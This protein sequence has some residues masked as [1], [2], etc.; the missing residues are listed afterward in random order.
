MKKFNIF[1]SIPAIAVGILLLVSAITFPVIAE[2][3]QL[4]GIE[5]AGK[6]LDVNPLEI[7]YLVAENSQAPTK[8]EDIIN[9][10][11]EEE[12]IFDEI[13]LL[14][15]NSREVIGLSNRE[16]TDSESERL[17]ELRKKFVKGMIKSE[18]TLPIG[19]NLE[20]PYYN[21][22]N[23]TYY[24]AEAEMT[25]EQLLQIID[26]DAKL[27]IAF[28]KFREAYI[29]KVMDNTDIRISEEEAIRIAKDTIENVYDVELDNMKITCS[30]D[31]TESNIG[32][33]W[34]VVFLPKNLDTLR[35]QEKLYWT[36]FSRVDVYDGKIIF[37]DSFYSNQKAERE[38]AAET[39]L[40]NIEEHKKLAEEALVD[41]L[42]I[43]D[44]E[45]LKAYI[46]K[47]DNLLKYNVTSKS[48]FLIYKAEDRYVEIEFLYGNKRMVAL[49]FY[50]DP[51]KLNDRVNKIE[52]DSIG[53]IYI[54]STT[55]IEDNGR[56]IPANSQVLQLKN[57]AKII[58]IEGDIEYDP[59]NTLF[60]QQ[61]R[62]SDEIF[63]KTGMRMDFIVG[64]IKY[65][66][67][68]KIDLTEKNLGIVNKYPLKGN[69]KELK[70]EEILPYKLVKGIFS[71]QSEKNFDVEFYLEDGQYAGKVESEF[72]HDTRQYELET[73]ISGV[74][75]YVAVIRNES[76]EGAID[77]K[78]NIFD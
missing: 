15:Q 57:G 48:L 13:V 51:E 25:D 63:K 5:K 43:K 40:Y 65:E 75:Y 72:N 33:T 34:T 69:I 52:Q 60:T 17:M 59:E 32:R 23:E 7:P 45:F 31:A 26:F 10:T 76:D 28:A 18:K 44:I 41:K 61:K 21:P 70:T 8:I 12:K 20:K 71:A 74:E 30:F 46:R 49:L 39:D 58:A 66:P 77:V 38:E 67:R 9:M 36:Y 2:N 53:T 24:Y 1:E 73:K 16:L 68:D 3:I 78:Y 37:L 47:P 11:E 64:M 62:I 50:D 55:V 6:D 54:N 35:E 22:E 27:D 14:L 4:K 19:E 29:Q 56:R 42:N